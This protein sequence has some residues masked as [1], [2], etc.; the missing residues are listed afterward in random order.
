[1]S[2]YS[3]RE[4]AELTGLTTEQI[5]RYARRGVVR[6]AREPNGRMRFD[7]QD[8]VLL[9]T[10]RALQ[11]ARVPIRRALTALSKLR[12]ELGDAAALTSLRIEAAG[13]AVVVHQEDG[14]WDASTGQ[15]QLNLSVRALAG[16]VANLRHRR[17]A[18]EPA[19]DDAEELFDLGVDLEELDPGRAET[20]YRRALAVDA[21]HADAHVNLGRLLQCRGRVADARRHYQR[22]L[23]LARD[24]QLALFNLGT[25][26][27]EQDDLDTAE[28]YYRRAAGVADAH[29]NLCRICELRGDRLAALRHLRRY[30]QLAAG[31][32]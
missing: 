24:H 25:L 21:R 17:F 11:D 29:Y 13:H 1:M 4:V 31:A 16:E 27:D 22:A 9:R 15:G 5:R 12:D 3:T 2:G 26:Y 6:P 14:L 28:G 10:A 19:S 30:R 32:D 8:M 23:E 18:R 20:V 7:F